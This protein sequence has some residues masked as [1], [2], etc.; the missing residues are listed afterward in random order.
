MSYLIKIW[1]LRHFLI[2]LVLSDLRTRWR[3]S[4]L[5]IF[6]SLL[7][8][9]GMTLLLVF[10]LGH[11]FKINMKYYAPYI[12][13]GIIVWEFIHFCL[14]SGSSSFIQADNYIKQYPH[15][16]SIYSLRIVLTGLLILILCTIP[17]FIWSIIHKPAHVSKIFIAMFIFYVLLILI[18]WPL[19]TLLA[20]LGARFRDLPPLLTLLLQVLWFISPVYFEINLFR[21]NGLEMLIDSNPIF[22]I[23]ELIRAPLLKGDWASFNDYLFSFILASVFIFFAWVIGRQVEKKVIFFL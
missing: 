23:L 2:H 11:F 13:S 22:H 7:Q 1:D 3:R 18:A 19:V 16:L 21:N 5:G 12:F 6:W 8:P 20:Y 17:L 15:P 9:L 10:V 4:F 14:I